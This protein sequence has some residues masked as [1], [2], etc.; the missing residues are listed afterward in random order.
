MVMAISFVCGELKSSEA[1]RLSDKVL[2]F[3]Q[4]RIGRK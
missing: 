3:A 2:A 4:A 1:E